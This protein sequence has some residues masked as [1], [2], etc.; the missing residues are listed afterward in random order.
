VPNTLTVLATV[1]AGQ[2]APLRTV[3]HAIGDDIKGKRIPVSCSPPRIDFVHSRSI[4]F[5]R[6]ALLDDPGT[7]PDRARLLF[8]SI[9]DGDFERHV[10]ELIRITS[11][12]Q[13]IWGRCE[14][15][16]GPSTF[17]EFVRS[18]A[19]DHEAFYIAFREETV[20]T[21]RSAIA[22][23]QEERDPT[24]GTDNSSAGGRFIRC[25]QRVIR[26]LPI[27]LD[28][29]R[30]VVRFGPIT[31]IRAMLRIIAS[32][33]RY[34]VFR[35]A[36]W[37]TRNRMPALKSQYSSV[38]L[39][40]CAPWRPVGPGDELPVTS[41][42]ATLPDY[43]EDVVTQNQLTLV[44]VVNPEHVDRVKAVMAAI[45]SYAKR[46]STPGSLIGV[47]TIHFVRWLLIDDNRRLVLLS[48]YDGSWENYIAEFAEMILSGLDAIW[49]TSFGYPPDGARDLPA[50]KRFL[51]AH[52][53]PA[54]MFYSAYPDAT[55]L[56]IAAAIGSARRLRE[57]SA[58]A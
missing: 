16:G 2:E 25:L 39:D 15:Y 34:P 46:L 30:A 10:A 41:V 14:G 35:F 33:D 6:F 9:Y 44:T 36:N 54:E 27:V 40:N 12:M 56:N 24:A 21:I 31:V 50:F 42:H 45:D 4:H 51:R 7:G 28:F 55:T 32:L 23:T 29:V 19:Q 43:R 26:G 53:V 3:L 8:A 11:D 57:Q 17:A 52:Q 37:I 20:D 49:E 38:T 5:A 58:G 48:D 18:H 22:L 47:G 1:R 13:A